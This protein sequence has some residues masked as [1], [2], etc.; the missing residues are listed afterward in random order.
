MKALVHTKVL[1][2]EYTEMPKPT[3]DKDSV[4]IKIKSVGICGSDIHGYTGGSGRRIPPLVMGHEASGQ[5]VEVNSNSKYKVGQKVTFDSTIH[6]GDCEYCNKGLVNLCS[7]RRVLGVSCNEYTQDGAMAEY[8]SLPERI[9]YSLDDN[10]D[11]DDAALIEPASVAY[12]SISL[13]EIKTNDNV[14]VIGAGV[15][16]LIIIQAL[17]IK[18][19]NNIIVADKNEKRLEISKYYGAKTVINTI[20]KDAT[21]ELINNYNDTI[22]VVFEAVGISETIGIGIEAVKKKGR[23]ILIGNIS[24]FVQM[25]LQKIVT[26]EIKIIGSCAIVDEY[27]IVIKHLSE[28]KLQFDKIITAKAPL[29]EGGKYF[30][31]IEEGNS[32]HIKVILNP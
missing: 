19:C 17:R 30:K 27:P 32:D 18:G 28:K 15:I 13:A 14:L 26:K 25:P 16:G 9:V 3:L 4:I 8:I 31:I 22:D 6:C 10:I 21:Y 23:V 29:S 20:E 24:E 2:M 5:I 7:Y 12:H 1:E 11:L